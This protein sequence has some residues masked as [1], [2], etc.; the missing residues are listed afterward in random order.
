MDCGGPDSLTFSQTG[1]WKGK[2]SG[3]QGRN[4]GTCPGPGGRGRHNQQC[5][6][7]TVNPLMGSHEKAPQP[8]GLL[9]PNVQLYSS[10]WKTSDIPK[11]MSMLNKTV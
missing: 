8:Y 6:G 2:Q 10:D 4:L 7:T 9:P 11:L 1:I 3:L 5:H